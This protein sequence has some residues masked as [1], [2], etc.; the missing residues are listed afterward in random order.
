MHARESVLHHSDERVDLLLQ[1]I[2]DPK[3]DV[4]QSYVSGVDKSYLTAIFAETQRLQNAQEDERTTSRE[5]HRGGCSFAKIIVGNRV[6]AFDTLIMDIHKYPR[7]HCIVGISGGSAALE[8]SRSPFYPPNALWH[9]SHQ[10][11]LSLPHP[12]MK[13]WLRRRCLVHTG[14][15][16]RPG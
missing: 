1:T 13:F 6:G 16:F 10:K 11:R 7:K 4:E 3:W 8:S 5:P 9:F 14:W 15:F 2:L 12:L